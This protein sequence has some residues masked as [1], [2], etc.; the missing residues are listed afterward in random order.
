VCFNIGTV[1]KRR[2]SKKIPW[3][4]AEKS[5]VLRFFDR[6]VRDMKKA[7]TKN[8]CENCI[9]E[10]MGALKLRDWKAVKYYVQYLIEKR[11]K[12]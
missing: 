7:P 12:K 10:A 9:R 8:Q 11:R 5:A 2:D 3:S 1:R 6:H 4:D